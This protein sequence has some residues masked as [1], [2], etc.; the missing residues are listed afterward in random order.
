MSTKAKITLNWQFE[1]AH[2]AVTFLLSRQRGRLS[3]CKHLLDGFTDAN[4][5]LIFP[6]SGLLLFLFFFFFSLTLL[7]PSPRS[8]DMLLSVSSSTLG[9]HFFLFFPFLGSHPC[10]SPRTHGD[11]RC[12]R[13]GYLQWPPTD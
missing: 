6:L 11:F 7:C 13:L 9:S 10:W 2:P 12:T 3:V 5:T 8:V 4:E 1:S